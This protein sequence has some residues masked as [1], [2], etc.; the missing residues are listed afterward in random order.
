MCGVYAGPNGLRAL[1]DL[2]RAPGKVAPD[3]AWHEI[4]PNLRAAFR[5]NLRPGH[6]GTGPQWAVPLIFEQYTLQWRSDRFREAGIT[7]IPQTLPEVRAVAKKL[8]GT[9]AG[10]KVYG[11]GQRGSKNWA[12]IHPGYM[13][14]FYSWGGRDFDASMHCTINSAAAVAVTDMWLGMVRESGPP[15]WLTQAWQDDAADFLSGTSSMLIDADI[16]VPFF[17]VPK[18]KQ[19]YGKIATTLIPAG[20]TGVRSSN[21]W[22]LGLSMPIKAPNPDGAWLFIQ[23]ASHPKTLQRLINAGSPIQDTVR[24]SVASSPAY[25]KSAMAAPTW[26]PTNRRESRFSRVLYTPQP[27]WQ[28]TMDT[29]VAALQQAYLQPGTTKQALS[30]AADQINEHMRSVGLQQ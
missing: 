20:P 16:E 7:K 21:M 18:N 28:F 15:H 23:W 12:T 14:M 1:D 24:P 8:T 22:A 11:I 4:L 6:L 26:L 13:S 30:A 29:W 9:M 19:V 2:L 3:Y 5:W 27:E 25:A 10:K 17:N